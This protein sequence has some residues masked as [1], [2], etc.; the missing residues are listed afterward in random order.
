MKKHGGNAYFKRLDPVLCKHA[1]KADPEG[2][3]RAF[4]ADI[5]KAPLAHLGLLRAA[6]RLDRTRPAP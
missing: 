3:V 2:V 4:A 5:E 1:S 6:Q